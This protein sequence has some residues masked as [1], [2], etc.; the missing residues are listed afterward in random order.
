MKE[1]IVA[2]SRPTLCAPMD[3]S[4]QAPLSMGF[5][6]QE[7]WSG[8]PFLSP[9]DLPNPEIKPGSPALRVDS[10]LSEPTAS[11]AVVVN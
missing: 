9:G 8:L 5:S 7:S 4:H 1:S 10:L 6:R 3:C 11:L 2:H